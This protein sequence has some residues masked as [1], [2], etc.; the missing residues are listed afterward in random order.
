VKKLIIIAATI[1]IFVFADEC[2]EIQGKIDNINKSV[3]VINK[4]KLRTDREWVKDFYIWAIR[5]YDMAIKI[6]EKEKEKCK[7]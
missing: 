7:A 3:K 2:L 4:K 5:K 1:S 6:L